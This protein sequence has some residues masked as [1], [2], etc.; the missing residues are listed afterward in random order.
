M[1]WSEGQSPVSISQALFFSPV[2]KS[3]DGIGVG[4]LGSSSF[5]ISDKCSVS[6]I[7]IATIWPTLPFP[8]DSYENHMWELVWEHL[9]TVDYYRKTLFSDYMC[10]WSLVI[11]MALR[12]VT[13]SPCLDHWTL[14][15]VLGLEKKEK[16]LLLVL[17]KSLSLLAYFPEP[18]QNGVWWIYVV[19]Q[20]SMESKYSDVTSVGSCTQFKEQHLP[21]IITCP[22]LI[23]VYDLEQVTSSMGLSFLLFQI[24]RG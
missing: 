21:T 16:L 18:H 9:P 19:G 12:T 23:T 14:A 22:F 4:H 17:S 24:L 3:H 7:K 1:T 20:P 8:R 13:N 10:S 15:S 6:F 5:M 11:H 2:T